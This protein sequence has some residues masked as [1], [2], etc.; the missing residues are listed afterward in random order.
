MEKDI[1]TFRGDRNVWIDFVS[2][3]KKD[4]KE[5]WGVLSKLISKYIKNKD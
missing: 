5:V 1:L 4:R 2:K 3:V